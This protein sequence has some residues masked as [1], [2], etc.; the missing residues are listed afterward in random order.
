MKK[1]FNQKGILLI[2]FLATTLTFT[3]CDKE[4]AG[5]PGADGVANISAH[6]FVTNTNAWAADNSS[7]VLIYQHTIP[8][9]TEDVVQSGA[10]LAY[11]GDGTGD[12]WIAMPLS[13]LGIDFVFG[14]YES[15]VEINVSLSNGEM[16]SNPGGQEFKVV[17]IPPA[18]RISTVDH[19][20]YE[21]VQHAYGLKK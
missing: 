3:S 20:D 19:Q 11:L 4:E 18:Q 21:Q 12:L 6:S 16:P 14:Y 9:I 7:N 5:P 1:A 10:V 8:E 17:I 15:N 13:T 2:A